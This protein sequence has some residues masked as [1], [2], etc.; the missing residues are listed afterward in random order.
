MQTDSISCNWQITPTD[1][2]LRM[3]N[4]PVSVLA[5]GVRSTDAR[6]ILLN[7]GVTEFRA[8]IIPYFNDII[9]KGYYTCWLLPVDYMLNF[10]IDYQGTSHTV[11]VDFTDL[12]FSYNTPYYGILEYFDR[13]MQ[14][15]ILIKDVV[16][17]GT[18]YTT[19]RIT[20]IYG[21]K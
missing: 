5:M 17:D 20:K 6:K 12:M 21:V 14:S 3:S 7:G 19:E 4:F 13:E 2:T 11:K 8:M 18:T 9:D 1:S 15:N 10:T 16:V